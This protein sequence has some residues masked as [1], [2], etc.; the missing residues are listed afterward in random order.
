M[1]IAVILAGGTGQRLDNNLPKQFYILGNKMVIEHS[2][3]IFQNH[4]DIDEIAVVSNSMYIK[5]IKEICSK[6][7]YFKV[8]KMLAGGAE[9]Y[10][11]SLTAINAYND[12]DANI[13][14]HDAVRPLVNTRIIS[15]CI[16]KLKH[17][18]AVNVGVTPSDTV[19]QVSDSDIITGMPFRNTLRNGQSPQGF[20]LGIIKKAYEMALKD[21][22]FKTTDDCSVVFNYLPGEQIY[23]VKG[24]SYNMKLT[25]R[26]DLYSLEKWLKSER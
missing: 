23:V 24:E 10:Q 26:E 17:Y 19:L 18:N 7:G 20:K 4:P 25:F 9:R 15:D 16:E 11:S 5:D 8:R 14:I 1:N 6:N 12:P 3:E 13:L 2:I 22:D 21:P